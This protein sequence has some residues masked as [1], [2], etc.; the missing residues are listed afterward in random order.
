MNAPYDA[1][2]NP[3]QISAQRSLSE[4]LNITHQT[5]HF[6]PPSFLDHQK[7]PPNLSEKQLCGGTSPDG[8]SQFLVGSCG[9]DSVSS[10]IKVR[11]K[12]VYEKKNNILLNENVCFIH[13][14]TGPTDRPQPVGK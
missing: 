7:T 13:K 11:R 4:M 8:G 14:G 1:K 2:K 6:S 3:G 10:C 12:I 9:T 5:L